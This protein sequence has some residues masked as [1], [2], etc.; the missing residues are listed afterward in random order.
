MAWAGT[1][2]PEFSEIGRDPGIPR[3][4]LELARSSEIID[5]HLDTFIPMRLFGYDVRERHG[6]GLLRG[7][8]FGHLDIPR[9]LEGGLAGGMWSITT[10][11]FRTTAGR[12]RTF[13]NNL[14]RLR[15]VIGD[16]NGKLRLVRN[17]QEY[18]AAR[19][20][21]AHACLLAVQGGN[22]FDG[23]PGSVADVPER[24]I[25]R[26]TLVH[27]TNSS[28]GTTSAPSSLLRRSRGLTSHGHDLVQVLNA[29]RVFVDLAHIHPEGFW[30]AVKVHDRSQPLIATHTGVCGVKPHW[31]NLDDP[32]IKAIA[33]TGGTIGIIYSQHF[34]KRRSGPRDARMVLEHMQHVIDVAGDEFVSIG[35]DYDGFIVPPPELRS[36]DSYQRLVALMLERGWSDVR[37]RRILGENFLRAFGMLRP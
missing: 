16:S 4:A 8:W 10:N 19:A 29:E 27:L 20:E 15:A 13:R 28:V 23:A 32:Q 25:T 37:I 22:C 7:R 17:L 5:L 24:V 33:D 6:L 3:E 18:G 9:A 14:D 11:P 34:L 1:V 21:N 2:T 26:V 36:G 12:W 35:S 30:D 31:R